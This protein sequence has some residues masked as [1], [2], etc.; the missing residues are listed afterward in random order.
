MCRRGALAVFV[1]DKRTG[2]CEMVFSLE[3][4]AAYI[5]SIVLT[6]KGMH[7]DC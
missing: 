7:E 1:W 5:G 6:K 4:E 2:N 3:Y